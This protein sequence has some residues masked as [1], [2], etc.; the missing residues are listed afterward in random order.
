MEKSRKSTE[1]DKK[2]KENAGKSQRKGIIIQKK[3]TIICKMQINFVTL[4][5]EMYSLDSLNINLKGLTDNDT[6]LDFSLND[7][8]F[9][10][11]DETEV[12]RGNVSV[13][14]DIHKVTD[15]CFELDFNIEGTVTVTCDRCLDDMLQPIS[16]NT[17]LVAQFG[18]EYSEDDDLVTVEEGSGI[19]NV[20][21][22]VYESIALQIP[23]KHVHAP[24]KC[25][26][27]M[28]DMLEEHSA[29]RSSDE[30]EQNID[31]RWS[32]LLKL[33]ENSKD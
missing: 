33:K 19:L 9:Q 31:P 1:S 24:G 3:K 26:R 5:P 25:N 8:Y 11:L 27:A 16:T 17:R 12:T 23:I 4:Q 22:F 7:D 30:E 29:T 21:W 10:S 18:E 2:P 6:R 32:A 13:G 14:V 28:I 20:A 15:S